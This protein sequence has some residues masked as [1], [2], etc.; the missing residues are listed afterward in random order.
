M[1]VFFQKIIDIL[2]PPRCLKCG[3]ILGDSNGLCPEC[4]N[5]ITF[6]AKP[7][8]AR[9]G[10]PLQN[11]TYGKQM[12]CGNCLGE[13]KPLFRLSRSAVCYDEFSKPLIL[14]FKFHDHTENASFL[15]RWMWMGG[16]DIFSRRVD[17][18]IP[19]PLHYT[20]MIKRRYNQSALLAKEL[21]KLCGVPADFASVVRHRKT[22]P[23]VEFSGH[24]RVKNVKDAFSVKYPA[25][26]KGKHVLLIDDVMTTGSTL[27]EC[28]R[29]ILAA[30]A[31]SVDTLTV[32]RVIK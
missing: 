17:A 23:Q 6:I 24:D 4:F 10:I 15:A 27:K 22:K 5:E 25:R 29:A 7:Y 28:A 20:R 3:K 16:K 14:D 21:S 30:G 31:A 9:C 8:C 32:A 18:I 12:L 19:I 1:Y 26:L 11:E 2:L 13:R